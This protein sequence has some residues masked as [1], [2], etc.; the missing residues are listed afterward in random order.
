MRKAFLAA[1]ALAFLS[2]V[3]LFGWRPGVATPDYVFLRKW[4][5][6]GTAD[7]QFRYPYGVAVDGAGNVYV[8]DRRNNRI[9][10]FGEVVLY[11]V[12]LP[13]IFKERG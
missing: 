2:G 3:L 5:T 9:Q 13:A 6:Q 8:S 4:G 11:R 12:Y 7:G 10:V 1:G